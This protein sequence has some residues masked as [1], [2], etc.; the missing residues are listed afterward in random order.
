MKNTIV[1]LIAACFAATSCFGIDEENYKTLE[2]I[3]ITAVSDTISARLGEELV[4]NGI[5]VKSGLNCSYEWV[6]GAPASGST[7]AEPKF[8][9]SSVI[10]A[11]ATID[12]T[13]TKIG[14]YILRL[15][16]DNGESIEFKYFTLN[17]NMGY[18]E[19]VVILNNDAGGN[20]ALTFVKTLTSEEIAAGEQEVFPDIFSS[21]NPNLRLK[22]GTAMFMSDNTMSNVMYSAFLIATDD[23]HGTIYHIEPKTFELFST[24]RMD[25]FGTYCQEFGGEYASSGGF[26]S[27]FRAADGSIFRYDMQ[28][29]YLQRM[30]DFNGCG[31][32]VRTAGLLN[33]SSAT[34]KST[35]SPFFFSE[36]TVSTRQSASAGIKCLTESGFNVVNVGCKRTSST[37]VYVLLQSRTDP[38]SYKIKYGAFSWRSWSSGSSFTNSS[39]KMDSFSK[40]INTKSSNDAYYV[41]GNAIYRWG[42]STAPGTMPAITL[43]EGETVCDIATNYMGKTAGSEGEDLLYVVTYNPSRSGDKKGSLYVYRFSDDSLVKSYEGICDKP[44]SVLYKYRLN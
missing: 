25:G 10:S 1:Y 9:G 36:D 20:G 40:I 29:G 16:V 11:S 35:I 17:V 19:G 27:F 38:E 3:E 37:P 30:D 13:F 44:A 5:S 23:E 34:G 32:I 31:S 15:K 4:Y 2:P 26:G 42:L 24:A 14:T 41:Y 6:Y 18:D 8:A 39:L 28:L 12:H 7:A 33:R 43:P 21:V 22:N